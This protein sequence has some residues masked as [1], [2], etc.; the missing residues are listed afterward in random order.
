MTTLLPPSPRPA[1]DLRK[2]SRLLRVS[3]A[4]TVALSV[5][6]IGLGLLARSKAITFDGF[7]GLV[8]AVITTVSL[9]ALKLIARGEDRRFQFGYWHLEPMLATANAVALVSGCVYAVVDGL[10][11]LLSR[12][13]AVELG[14]SAVYAGAMTLIGLVMHVFVRR[15]GRGLQ[16]QLLRI[17]AQSW[18]VGALLTGGLFISFAIALAARAAGAVGWPNY[19]DPVVLIVA[20]L[21]LLPVP[22]KTLWSAGRELFQIAPPDLDRRVRAVAREVAERH[23][24]VDFS[25]HVAQAGRL[26]TVE[27]GLVAGSPADILSFAQ[28]D[29]IRVELADRLRGP[30]PGFWLTVDFTADRRWI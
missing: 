21:G 17:D 20:G 15:S 25:S 28:M 12:P 24:F 14:L 8:D 4:A 2:E 18:L 13:P 7:Y 10:S 9:A 30:T 11:G 16:S 6:G 23:G 5:L 3:I 22:A 19:I 27:I 26:Q 29:A 1:D